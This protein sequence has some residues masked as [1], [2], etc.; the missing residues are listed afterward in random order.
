MAT[1]VVSGAIA[2]LLSRYPDM[3]N[4]EIKLRLRET[5][6]RVSGT[7]AGT[8]WGMLRVDKLLF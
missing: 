5:C 8:G 2:M 1:P 7:M 6:E 4:V 3:S